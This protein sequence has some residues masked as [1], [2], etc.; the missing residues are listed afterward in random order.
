MVGCS[1]PP[2]CRNRQ[3]PLLGRL[4]LVVQRNPPRDGWQQEVERLS[5]SFNAQDA[6]EALWGS[7]A[8]LVQERSRDGAQ[9]ETPGPF[10]FHRR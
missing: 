10:K 5:R 9:N 2:L 3:K 4:E 8:A 1:R 7:Q 6:A